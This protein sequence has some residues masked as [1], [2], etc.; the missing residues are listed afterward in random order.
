MRE[1]F[2]R[3]IAGSMLVAVSTAYSDKEEFL[4]RFH[5]FEPEAYSEEGRAGLAQILSGKMFDFQI[6]MSAVNFRRS[7]AASKAG[8]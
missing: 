3:V 1:G 4:L 8:E 7:I 2:K 5:G 6:P